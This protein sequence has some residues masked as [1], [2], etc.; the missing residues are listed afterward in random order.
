VASLRK[1]N[2]IINNSCT[3]SYVIVAILELGENTFNC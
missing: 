1:W 3:E 2:A